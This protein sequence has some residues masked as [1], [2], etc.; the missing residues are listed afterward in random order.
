MPKPTPYTADTDQLLLDAIHALR[1]EIAEF[2]DAIDELREEIQWGNRNCSGYNP[3]LFRHE[4]PT[5]S[6]NIAAEI[7]LTHCEPNDDP[8]DSTPRRQERLW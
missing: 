6:P 7:P 5:A 8:G 4:R 3:M 1:N 2:R